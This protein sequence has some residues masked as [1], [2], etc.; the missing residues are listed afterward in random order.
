[1]NFSPQVSDLQGLKKDWYWLLVLGLS[2]VVLGTIAITVPFF[3]TVEVVTILGILMLMAGIAQVISAF[4]TARWKGFLLQML[5]GILY[6]VSGFLILEN[7]VEGAAGLTLLMAAFFFTSGVFRIAV[8]MTE[9]FHGWGWT[10]LNGAVN[11]LLGL[12]IWQQFPVSALW[13]IGLLVGIEL[14]FN[15]WTW[16]MLAFAVKNI[17]EQQTYTN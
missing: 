17:P 7:P 14:L 8:A 5:M 6:S 9:R 11:V 16:V 10:L 4:Q 12:V 13:M 3:A 1:M 2:L 15:G